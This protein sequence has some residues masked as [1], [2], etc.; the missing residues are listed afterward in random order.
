MDSNRVTK[1][2]AGVGAAGVA[3]ALSV[4]LFWPTTEDST[5]YLGWRTGAEDHMPIRVIPE[6]TPDEHAEALVPTLGAETAENRK[7]GREA[8]SALLAQGV[9]LGEGARES[10]AL[11]LA[12]AHRLS[13]GATKD[14]AAERRQCLEL[15]IASVKGDTARAYAEQVLATGE[16]ADKAAILEALVKPGALRGGTL[17]EM[18]YELTKTPDVPEALK[19]SVIRKVRGKAA[20]EEL[21]AFVAETKD[22]KALAA[23]AVEV[24][25]LHKA[26]LL[27]SVISRLD[28]MEMLNDSKRMPW[29]SG[30]LLSEHIKKSEGIVLVRALR[31]VWARPSLTRSTFKA[32]QETLASADPAVRRMAARLVP[33]AVKYAALEAEEGEKTLTARLE[34]ETDPAVKGELEAVLGEVRRNRQ[35][36]EAQAPDAPAE[37]A[38]VTP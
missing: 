6:M 15:L 18:A 19:P 2:A 22:K 13:S 3:A 34:V 26:E 25:N 28:E 29:F 14:E 33:D 37:P 23:A 8:L 5:R 10:T 16:N 12:E 17:Y 32:V 27:G 1:L 4:G 31:V 11:A 30:A 20:A 36:A 35:S 38:P 21:T 9:T 7:L 24:Q